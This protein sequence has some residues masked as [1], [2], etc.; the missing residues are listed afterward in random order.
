MKTKRTL[1]A[2]YLFAILAFIYCICVGCAHRVCAPFT[3]IT[4]DT[5]IECSID[6]LTQVAKDS[7]LLMLLAECDSNNN[8]IFRELISLQG[9]RNRLEWKL[10]HP[11]EP[12]TPTTPTKPTKPVIVIRSECDSLITIYEKKIQKIKQQKN[13]Q[14]VI[15]ER[16]SLK[17]QISNVVFLF[18]CGFVTGIIFFII[19]FRRKIFTF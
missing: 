11:D 5:T 17:E 19:I 2:L 15:V 16:P 7:T 10:Y 4:A 12:T 6:T 3:T 18:F 9:E 13:T 8:V 14:R 1:K